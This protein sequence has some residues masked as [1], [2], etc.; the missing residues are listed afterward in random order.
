MSYYEIDKKT[1]RIEI[2]LDYIPSP[3][4]RELLKSKRWWW[5]PH[6]GC[7]WNKYD[8]L[9]LEFAESL[10]NPSKE[11]KKEKICTEGKCGLSVNWYFIDGGLYINGYGKM[12]D[13]K[14]DQ[15]K[16]IPWYH[17]REEIEYVNVEGVRIIGCR[18]FYSLP[19]LTKVEMD[20]SVEVIGKR[21]FSKCENL[22][23]VTL[24]KRLESIEKE[25]FE[26]CVSIRVLHIPASIMKL[27]EDCFKN[28][29]TR[30]KIYIAKKD[31]ATGKTTERAYSAKEIND[32]TITKIGFE[33]F[34]TVTTNNF[35]VNNG[36]PYE[37]IQAKISLLRVDGTV[38]TMMVPAGYCKVC[39]KYVIGLWQYNNLR[40]HGVIL[41]RM[42]HE[43]WN[44]PISYDD[45]YEELSPESI[46]K[47]Y[48]Y[49]VNS[50]DDLSD[51]QREFILA[52]LIEFKICS[53]QKITSHLSWLI[54]SREGQ[55][56]MS[57]A[58][59]KWRQ[60]RDF[61]DQYN[62]ENARVVGMKSLLV[63]D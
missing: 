15:I 58:I 41:C 60:D 12:E 56:N 53:K 45:Y 32:S 5:N 50:T 16:L 42:V 10:C 59:S 19:K 7:W 31:I 23:T 51:E 21:A 28:W 62:A 36:H 30:Q 17:L 61:V 39:K 37:D 29:K 18:A 6:S 49:S 47:Q 2:Y 44:R 22:R 27:G 14:Y 13:Y 11:E 8:R 55:M 34:V 33:D 48:G 63:H 24:S 26:D 1:N 25:A 46:L 54:H 35:C 20:N 38:F 3:K 9:N 40:K 43:E 57:N 4:K 52:R